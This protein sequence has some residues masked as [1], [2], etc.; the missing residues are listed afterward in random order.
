MSTDSISVWIFELTHLDVRRAHHGGLV[1]H[2][3]PLVGSVSLRHQPSLPCVV[4]VTYADLALH[5]LPS[6]R[7]APLLTHRSA[8]VVVAIVTVF[9][10]RQGAV[11][12]AGVDEEG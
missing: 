3:R 10:G 5:S 2:L 7:A 8:V 4:R 6:L 11:A 1:L 9:W 12:G